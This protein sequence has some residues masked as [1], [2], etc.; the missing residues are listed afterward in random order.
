MS[1]SQSF[2]A[3]TDPVVLE[4]IRCVQ[5]RSAYREPFA[6]PFLDQSPEVIR[7][8]VKS[9]FPGTKLNC[10][11]FIVLDS[12]ALQDQTCIIADMHTISEDPNLMLVR[13]DFCNALALIVS[14]TC[15]SL[16]FEVM[17]LDQVR[18]PSKASGIRGNP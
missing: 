12:I 15:T 18:S 13:T 11:F 2:F 9:Q 14:T 5:T 3:E 17:T 8:S 16:D 10:A 1:Y 4:I 7:Q 6:S